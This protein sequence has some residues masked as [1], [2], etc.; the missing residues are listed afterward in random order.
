MST[1]KKDGGTG[2][3]SYSFCP[4]KVGNLGNIRGKVTLAMGRPLPLYS[5]FES[6]S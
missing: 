6:P 5:W 2:L 1:N 4:I 3:A